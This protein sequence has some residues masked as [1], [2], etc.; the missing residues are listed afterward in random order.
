MAFY[1]QLPLVINIKLS[2]FHSEIERPKG[3]KNGR[4]N[5]KNQKAPKRSRREDIFSEK[6]RIEKA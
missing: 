3:D 1:T 4:N 2:T 6:K 5:L